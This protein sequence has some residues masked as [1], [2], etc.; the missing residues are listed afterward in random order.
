MP[1]AT[2][3]GG[4]Q[5]AAAAESRVFSRSVMGGGLRL[6]NE[7]T[8]SRS[9]KQKRR[10]DHA[11]AARERALAGWGRLCPVRWVTPA[12]GYRLPE[13]HEGL[14]YSLMQAACQWLRGARCYR[15]SSWSA[16]WTQGRVPPGFVGDR[17]HVFVRCTKLN[18]F[19]ACSGRVHRTPGTP[20]RECPPLRSSFISLRGVPGALC[21]V[22]AV[23]VLADQPPLCPTL[24]LAV[25]S[26]Q[27]NKGGAK[28]GTFAE[29]ST[30][31]A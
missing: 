21:T 17:R 6:K 12:V 22:S 15:K 16:R 29:Q 13:D 7:Q 19:E 24:T 27:R 30:P 14:M 31:S 11:G 4:L 20:L 28:R 1:T 18:A 8:K 3:G 10:P 26:A 9:E 25:C 2:D 23:V 5:H